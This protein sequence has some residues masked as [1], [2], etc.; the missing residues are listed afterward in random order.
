MPIP[1]A[2]LLSA[3]DRYLPENGWASERGDGPSKGLQFASADPLCR[4]YWV[5][6]PLEARPR[7]SA[8]L[9]RPWD[10]STRGQEIEEGLL[11]AVPGHHRL[12]LGIVA[13]TFGV[14]HLD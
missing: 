3:R 1:F 6:V 12:R 14:D 9:P 5:A 2:D 8:P 13:H 4:R 11:H 7:V 10:P